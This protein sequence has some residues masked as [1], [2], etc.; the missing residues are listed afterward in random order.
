MFLRKHCAPFFDAPA[1]R[2]R[3]HEHA[4]VRAREAKAAFVHEP[5]MEAAER[6][7]ISEL[8]FAAVGP[9]FDVVPFAE[10]RAVA[11]GEAATAVASA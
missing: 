9:V 10:A 3:E 2:P 8:R 4:V 5:M 1:V 6:D 11:A 7:E